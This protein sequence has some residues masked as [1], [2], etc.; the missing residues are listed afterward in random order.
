MVKAIF[1]EIPNDFLTQNKRVSTK[2]T[3]L[4]NKNNN[5]LNL[6]DFIRDKVVGRRTHNKLMN[7]PSNIKVLKVGLHQENNL[8]SMVNQLS[9]TLRG[10]F[11]NNQIRIHNLLQNHNRDLNLLLLLIDFYKD[12]MS[13]NQ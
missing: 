5:P 2:T 6:K 9:I 3:S 8:N 10:N 7:I 11:L 4:D 1:V 12:L 13:K